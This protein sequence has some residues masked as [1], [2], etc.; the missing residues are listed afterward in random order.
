MLFKK[1]FGWIKID[2]YMLVLNDERTL[3]KVITY[4]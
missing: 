4:F 3:V 1:E 2:N